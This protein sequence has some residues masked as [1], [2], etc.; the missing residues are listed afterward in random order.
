[1]I[2]F[3]DIRHDVESF[4]WSCMNIFDHDPPFGYTI[5]LWQRQR[6]PEFILFGLQTQLMHGILTQFAG[7]VGAGRVFRH[8]ER[9]TD[10]GSRFGFVVRSVW[11]KDVERYMGA[12][13]G[14]Y[15]QPF[16]AMQ[17]VWPDPSG[18]FPWDEE[19]DPGYVGAQ[20][21]ASW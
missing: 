16:K 13:I 20:P 4:G 10:L 15:E 2:V 5:G 1:L 18:R 21:D 3:E 14:Y 7:A 19:F 9:V 6:H 11:P 12:A 8:E 17:V